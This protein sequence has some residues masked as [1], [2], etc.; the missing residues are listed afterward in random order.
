MNAATA[1]LMV[2]SRT[3]T[4]GWSGYW[5]ASLGLVWSWEQT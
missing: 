5:A 4:R 3:V 1:W 2:S